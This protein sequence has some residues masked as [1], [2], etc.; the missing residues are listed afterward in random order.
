M[1]FNIDIYGIRAA[2]A[3]SNDA[4]DNAM[5][6]SC[7]AGDEVMAL[8]VSRQ[9]LWQSLYNTYYNDLC[10]MDDRHYALDDFQKEDMA[11]AF[12]EQNIEPYANFVMNK[13]SVPSW[14]MGPIAEYDLLLKS[15]K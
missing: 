2:I 15:R 9:S 1:D 11:R 12:A 8:F 4:I 10:E 5:R 14:M 13:L 3:M 7:E 6:S